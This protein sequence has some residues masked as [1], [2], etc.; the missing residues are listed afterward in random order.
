[1]DE[2]QQKINELEKTIQE[3]RD[4]YAPD[5]VK[6]QAVAITGPDRMLEAGYTADGGWVERIAPIR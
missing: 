1:M 5:I 6:L 2:K 4:W 3:L